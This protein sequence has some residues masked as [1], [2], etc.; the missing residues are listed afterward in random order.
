MHHCTEDPL[1]LTSRFRGLGPYSLDWSE[2]GVGALLLFFYQKIIIEHSLVSVH[3]KHYL[4]LLF[5]EELVNFYRETALTF[6]F[7][8]FDI[9]F[10]ILSL[11]GFAR[12][13]LF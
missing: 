9:F 13:L 2:V 8:D 1:S 4:C 11:Y 5:F 7:C 12:V 6:L 3:L 10:Y